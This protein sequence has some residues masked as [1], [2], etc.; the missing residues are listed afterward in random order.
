MDTKTPLIPLKHQEKRQY[1][2]QEIIA[3][4]LSLPPLATAQY[5]NAERQRP[6]TD[7]KKNSDPNWVSAT[8]Y[9]TKNL[10]Q[11]L[12]KPY[13]VLHI[14]A[15]PL[16]HACQQGERSRVL[17]LLNEQ[18]DTVNYRDRTL[19]NTLHYCMDASTCGA[20]ASAAPQLV[21]APDAEGHTPLHLAVIAGDTQLVA[22]LLANGANVNAKDLEGHSVLHWA[23][24]CGEAECVRLVLAAGAKPSTPDLRGGSPL[25][26]AAQCCGAA[27][28]AELSV[29]KKVGLKVLH[30]LLEFGADVN[31]KDEDGRQPILWAAS[32]G[33]VEAVLALVRAG[34]SA[35]A[36]ATDKDGL[37][38][39]H[40][41]ASRGHARCVEAL[42]NLC[43]LQP[44]YVDDNGCS[45]VHYAATLGHADATALLLRLGADPN[46]QDRKGRTPALCAAAKGQLETLKILAQH[47]GS[48]HART[49]R[50]TGVAHEAVL[51]GRIEL[52][53]WLAKK[54]PSTLDVATHDGRTPLHVAALHGYLDICKV[55]LDHGV[56]INAIFQTIKSGSMTPLDAA[57]YR[58][59][60][61]CA[62][63]IQMHGGITAH[64]V[65]MHR[66]TP[67]RVFAAKV[68]IQRSNSTSPSDTDSRHR[69]HR[70]AD[71]YIEEKWIEQR[72]RRHNSP[73]KKKH[74]RRRSSR[75]FSEEEMR[76]SKESR[77]QRRRRAKS[78]SSRYDG[79][80]VESTTTTCRRKYSKHEYSE[81]SS[82]TDDDS[83]DENAIIKREIHRMERGNSLISG[84]PS[85]S[86][87]SLEVVVVKKSVEKKSE[88]IKYSDGKLTKKPRETCKEIRA[89]CKEIQRRS[90]RVKCKDEKLKS[91]STGNTKRTIEHRSSGGG[92]EEKD[93]QEGEEKN[94]DPSVKEKMVE[95][96]EKMEKDMTDSTSQETVEHVTVTAI[97]HKD[98]APDTPIIGAGT[99]IEINE[100]QETSKDKINYILEKADEM[101]NALMTKAADMKKDVEDIRRQRNQEAVSPLPDDNQCTKDDNFPAKGREK[102]D[103][104]MSNSPTVHCQQK[105][106][107]LQNEPKDNYAISSQSSLKN[108]IR[109]NNNITESIEGEQSKKNEENNDK[110]KQDQQNMVVSLVN[111]NNDNV[112]DNEFIK[113]PNENQFSAFSTKIS[114]SE[115]PREG[116]STGELKKSNGQDVINDEKMEKV[117]KVTTSSALE[118]IQL[119]DQDIGASSEIVTNQTESDKHNDTVSIS[120]KDMKKLTNSR[121]STA[122]SK[123]SGDNLFGNS[124]HRSPDRSAI[125][126]VIESPEWD[127]ED[128]EVV[129]EIQNVVDNNTELE[130]EPEYDDELAVLRVLPSTS[131]EE[132]PRKP[133]KIL[134][135]TKLDALTRVD[136]KNIR[137]SKERRDSG[138][139]DSGIEPSP[140]ISKIPKRSIKCYP[141]TEKHQALNMDTI[142]R[143]V[144]INLRRYHLERKIFFQLMELKR[145][146][147]RHGRANEHI[148]VKRQVE[149]FNKS[150]MSGPTLGVAR[151]DQPLTFRHF[152]G[153]LYE[154]LRRLQKRPTTPDWCTEARQCTQKTHRCHHA[155]S[156]Y[157]SLPIYTYH[158]NCSGWRRP[159]ARATKHTSSED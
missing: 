94:S 136:N 74:K 10:H 114:H 150:G 78:E 62:K 143:D 110:E 55:L 88:K 157:T 29:P 87:D 107:P 44:D 84:D 106:S 42:V 1:K 141:N 103:N 138:G 13:R 7:N 112:S 156:A 15:T 102:M 118:N 80:G 58:G 137:I 120:S 133:M 70:K 27:V 145:L 91:I 17:R 43:G 96:G 75:S 134:E 123:S 52:I 97:V 3:E 146:Q 109:D 18:G 25:H 4:H 2:K 11:Q 135:N 60:R 34:G 24:V 5:S 40:C 66:E 90:S 139:R 119:N 81:S 20:V 76:I 154:Q 57:L 147:I 32:A 92:E 111:Q 59:H 144:Q 85:L 67:S 56:R 77:R 83:S 6:S 98:Q 48:L 115:D 53:E 51:S 9:V 126:A 73:S 35:A 50:G 158:Y 38:A 131:E 61:D 108:N 65:W 72:T 125:V 148:L 69:R 22:V 12:N 122:K 71:V 105:F 21:N 19:R 159:T 124:E 121:P 8:P 36:G 46:R 49:V 41:A 31:A 99:K 132:T 152:E 140:R 63:L 101:Q 151:Y 129:K 23:T 153:Y 82:E 26:Y 79:T 128:E 93:G 68:K 89:T 54:K 33:S 113:S 86:D 14:G 64:H 47:G 28:T 116:K 95:S 130:T 16:M 149:S 104:V 127:E 30:T 117:D 45:A 37:T 100:E 142:Q 39:L 155:T